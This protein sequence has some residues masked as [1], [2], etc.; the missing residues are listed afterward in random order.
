MPES[1]LL[2]L[3]SAAAVVIV[4]LVAPQP[5]RNGQRS[6]NAKAGSL[7]KLRDSGNYWGVTLQNGK[8]AAVRRCLGR[9]YRFEEA[10]ALPVSGCKALRCS[11]T[12]RGL[13]ERRKRQRRVLRDRREAVRFDSDHPERRSNGE[14]RRGHVR[15]RDADGRD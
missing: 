6:G 9:Q 7:K 4:L 1:Q 3:A 10:P 5:R 8:C 12:Y 15:W 11:C 14:R 2:L 13:P